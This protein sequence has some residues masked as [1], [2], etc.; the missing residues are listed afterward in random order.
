MKKKT[1]LWTSIV[2]T[3]ANEEQGT[4]NSPQQSQGDETKKN[5]RERKTVHGTDHKKQ[6]VIA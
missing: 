1:C 5:I 3:S 6:I 4:I 2:K